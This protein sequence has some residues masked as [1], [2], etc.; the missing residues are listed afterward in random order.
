MAC[1]FCAV[2]PESVTL[3][4][5]TRLAFRD[6]SPVGEGHPFGTARGHPAD[7]VFG[8]NI[9]RKPATEKSTGL[10]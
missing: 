9:M 3:E 8:E 6:V 7:P 2:S 1:P 4:N 10:N 5:D